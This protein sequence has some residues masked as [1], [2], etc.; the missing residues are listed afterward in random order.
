[1]ATATLTWTNPT[2]RTD[3]TAFT[4]DMIM[5]IDVFDSTSPTP[6]VPIGTPTG[7]ATTFT[8]DVLLVGVHNFTVVVRDTTGHSSA[9]SNVA[10]ITVPAVLANPAAVADLAAT[11]N[12]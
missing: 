1:M 3:G 5:E 6:G 7:A 11:L 2:T 8:T 10:T 4:P 12:P 9:S